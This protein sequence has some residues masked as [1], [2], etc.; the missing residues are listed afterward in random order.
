MQRVAIVILLPAV[1]AVSVV[2]PAPAS[3]TV[4][5]KLFL[6]KD[7]KPGIDVSL[8][9]LV[10]VGQELAPSDNSIVGNPTVPGSIDGAYLQVVAVGGTLVSQTQDFAMPSARWR[11]IP[12]DLAKPLVGYKYTD[13]RPGIHGA[14]RSAVIKAQ[15]GKFLIK[16]VIVGANGPGPQP[17]IMLV[18]PDPG[19]TA[20]AIFTLA[21]G[22]SYCITYGGSAGGRVGNS[23]TTPPHN[24]VFRVTSTKEEPTVETGCPNLPPPS[25]TTTTST[26]TSSSSTTTSTTLPPM[27]QIVA[28]VSDATACSGGNVTTAVTLTPFGVSGDYT[29]SLERGGANIADVVAAPRAGGFSYVDT[30]T[31][32]NAGQPL[33]PG[34]YTLRARW[35]IG[36]AVPED[37]ATLTIVRIDFV[38]ASLTAGTP[39]LPLFNPN[40]IVT[41]D[42]I[43]N[44]GAAE[45][46]NVN[47]TGR[48]RD[49][50][51]PV[52]KV[53]VNGAE[54]DVTPTN[55]G[56]DGL[57]PFQGTF[58]APVTLTG[59]TTLVEATA[60]NSLNNVGKDSTLITVTR[61]ADFTLTARAVTENASVP[62]APADETAFLDGYRFKIELNGVDPPGNQVDVSLQTD[63]ETKTVTLTRP[64]NA[65]PLRSKDL[66]LVPENLTLPANASAEVQQT[67]IKADLGKRPVARYTSG[68]LVCAANGVAKGILLRKRSDATIADFV[69][70]A[71]A[72]DV[73]DP[74]VG[75]QY[76]MVVGLHGSTGATIDLTLRGLDNAA[77]ELPQPMPTASFPPLEPSITLTRQ[78][79]DSVNP[80]YH[81][82][83]QTV[84]PKPVIGLR[85]PLPTDNTGA[86]Q[87]NAN[88]T[89]VWVEFDGGLRGRYQP[90]AQ[91]AL[92]EPVVGMEIVADRQAA[93]NVFKATGLIPVDHPAP[94]VLS[95]AD[96]TPRPI[97]ENFMV[98]YAPDAANPRRF[99]VQADV[100]DQLADL[101]AGNT[102]AA[103]GMALSINGTAVPAANVAVN[104]PANDPP[105]PFVAHVDTFVNLAN[106]PQA[107]D[108][109]AY[110]QGRGIDTRPG[111]AHPTNITISQEAIILQATN[112][113]GNRSWDS[114]FCNLTDTNADGNLP[115]TDTIVNDARSAP[116]RY[117][118]APQ[119][120]FARYHN[121]FKA[122]AN[123]TQA[124]SSRTAAGELATKQVQLLRR[125]AG[126][127]YGYGPF[128]V[129]STD[130]WVVGP[131]ALPALLPAIAGT[132]YTHDAAGVVTAEAI[133]A[134]LRIDA[135][136]PSR[137]DLAATLP[138][139]LRF[140]DAAAGGNQ[141]DAFLPTGSD[142]APTAVNL[143]AVAPAVVATA[144]IPAAVRANLTM[145]FALR[146]VT[147]FT[148]YC[149]N[150]PRA[151]V[152]GLAN[153]DFSFAAGGNN[154]GPTAAA[155]FDANGE[156]RN[157]VRSKDYGGR[158]VLDASV[159]IPGNGA[160]R[161]LASVVVDDDGD[162]LPRSWER[163]FRTSPGVTD[164]SNPVRDGLEDG[165]NRGLTG[166]A[167][168][169]NE[170]GD[171]FT[172]LEEYRGFSVTFQLPGP[173]APPAPPLAMR[174]DEI[175]RAY[176]VGTTAGVMGPRV[177][178]VLV[179]HQSTVT[180][181]PAPANVRRTLGLTV[182]PLA[183]VAYHRI[184]VADMAVNQPLTTPGGAPLTT[185]NHQINFS[186]D[187]DGFGT[188][189]NAIHIRDDTTVTGLAVSM[190][191]SLNSLDVRIN[192]TRAG[193]PAGFG[194]PHAQINGNTFF[195]E[196][197]HK[198]SLRH[199]FNA[200]SGTTAVFNTAAYVSPPAPAAPVIAD[201]LDFFPYGAPDGV[202]DGVIRINF[203]T[204]TRPDGRP[205]VL[206]E[207]SEQIFVN[208][209]DV[210]N[211]HTRR[212][213]PNNDAC[214]N[215]RTEV[216]VF[217]SLPFGAGPFFSH[218]LRPELLDWM[219]Y[220][221]AAVAGPPAVPSGP[222]QQENL[223]ERQIFV[224]PGP[225][226]DGG[227]GAVAHN[228][229]IRCRT[230]P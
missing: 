189:Q 28:G 224:P 228:R 213:A 53:R 90:D 35:D 181:V 91:I 59:N 48:V 161:V 226:P 126:N 207:G 51:A 61:A 42:P 185:H 145:T 212:V 27:V 71:I 10:V 38:E 11:R 168:V 50:I 106:I 2:A 19:D 163:R 136:A 154:Q 83:K 132:A 18:P 87:T 47:V 22:D 179:L 153:E 60:I 177:K 184:A 92:V 95:V 220:F 63:V 180:D 128:L 206:G 79:N 104:R 174:M 98:T 31:A 67:R 196:L 102:P 166:A 97:I 225:A 23:P 49:Y 114:A 70:S 55:S 151:G 175:P 30:W 113:A 214:G 152:A 198:M 100:R 13:P 203:A 62:A 171:G 54:V 130:R 37:T 7:P 125:L 34:S 40:P 148:G 182:A 146:D 89:F 14:V 94:P 137:E 131:P 66:F 6:L 165:E 124:L 178:D 204:Y 210:T 3:Q 32:A 57:G 205:C 141:R 195:H 101:V 1:L 15:A 33:A 75:L 4:R 123:F 21:D 144:G 82:Y 109:I 45:S 135:P 191:F 103:V 12:T 209:R 223:N 155:A 20:A 188:V 111:A 147:T 36:F 108:I 127:T 84:A 200:T 17:H 107:V 199:S 201:N 221:A 121:P 85:T 138:L 78:S 229:E 43:A 142:A 157:I 9:R 159:T 227:A 133:A 16:I 81:L 194:F 76:E 86:P 149:T 56:P 150:A 26:T 122:D 211:S 215:P 25:T 73:A 52:G 208:N 129:P 8:R 164:P 80:T 96:G 192:P 139:D 197:G 186:G 134:T 44:P 170:Q 219:D 72:S 65:G 68:A 64:G 69:E 115:F 187:N 74:G 41:L 105:R 218:V 99:R 110:T 173:P 143:T 162:F 167:V 39:M 119:P 183:N 46:V 172:A 5:G 169:H 116:T 176:G 222:T 112:V 202:R 29:L 93:P 24:K 230:Q 140:S 193:A 120:F 216:Y 217:P 190:G 77:A 156:V 158:A 118:V 117:D 160:R 88:M 58:T